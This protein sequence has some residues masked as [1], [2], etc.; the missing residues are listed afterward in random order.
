MRISDW[1]SDVCSSD[2]S[3]LASA[4]D[5]IVQVLPENCPAFAGPAADMKVQLVGRLQIASA[6]PMTSTDASSV[7]WA[8]VWARAGAE[9][10]ARA[11]PPPRGRVDFMTARPPWGSTDS[12]RA[13][14]VMGS[15]L[16]GW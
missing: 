2:L 11:A 14:P 9:E 10:T 16:A 3:G 1:S 15:S 5:G 13:H 8:H 4:V 7:V 12:G 6:L